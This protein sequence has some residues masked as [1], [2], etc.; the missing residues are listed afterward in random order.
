MGSF[1]V[2]KFGLTEFC[3][4]ERG[5]K[6]GKPNCSFLFMA[7]S[8][9]LRSDAGFLY[10]LA[11]PCFAKRIDMCMCIPA[12]LHVHTRMCVKPEMDKLS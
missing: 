2:E 7:Y 3:K 1:K 4:T 6:A 11:V 12:Y 5:R 10:S 9:L 8:E